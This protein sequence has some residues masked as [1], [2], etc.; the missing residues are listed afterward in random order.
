MGCERPTLVDGGIAVANTEVCDGKGRRGTELNVRVVY[1]DWCCLSVV[2]PCCQDMVELA[3]T[4]SLQ[5]FNAKRT[6]PSDAEVCTET[7]RWCCHV[8]A[9]G[10][11]TVAVLIED[12]GGHFVAQ[13]I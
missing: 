6:Y 8:R 3:C 1:S 5:C 9:I 13:Y 11:L 7:G 10:I 2:V 12:D 4:G